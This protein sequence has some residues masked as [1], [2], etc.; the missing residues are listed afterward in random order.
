MPEDQTATF[1]TPDSH[2]R[3]PVQPVR[4]GSRAEQK[5]QDA[6]GTVSC[7]ARGRVQ[8]QGSHHQC[9]TA[10]YGTF[11]FAMVRALVFN[12]ALRQPAVTV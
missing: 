4:Q 8:E 2:W 3:G 12:F 11:D 5:V 6:A 10:H 9:G 7:N 1:M